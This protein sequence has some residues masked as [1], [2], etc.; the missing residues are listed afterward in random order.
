MKFQYLLV[1]YAVKGSEIY[2]FVS[3][4][5]SKCFLFSEKLIKTIH[6][7]LVL[8]HRLGIFILDRLNNIDYCYHQPLSLSAI[9]STKKIFS[10][11]VSE[12]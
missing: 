2:G 10:E 9:T 5:V 12:F 4:L 3:L 7:C 1:L 8:E 11:S 6:T